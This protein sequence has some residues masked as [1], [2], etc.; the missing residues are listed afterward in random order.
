MGNSGGEE[1]SQKHHKSGS[2]CK[3][4]GRR[5]QPATAT[6]MERLLCG[7]GPSRTGSAVTSFSQEHCVSQ[8]CLSPSVTPDQGHLEKSRLDQPI[9]CRPSCL[10]CLDRWPSYGGGANLKQSKTALSESQRVPR[11]LTQPVSSL[12]QNPECQQ[13]NKL[14]LREGKHLSQ[15]A[16]PKTIL[17]YSSQQTAYS[18]PGLLRLLCRY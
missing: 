2:G 17:G 3:P 9:P 4:E 1:S 10:S 11:I 7:P 13:K 5:P 18:L 8:V 16:Q 14:K 15:V 6:A 12:D